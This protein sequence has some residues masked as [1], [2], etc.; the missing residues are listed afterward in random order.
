MGLTDNGRALFKSLLAEQRA[1]SVPYQ[2]VNEI[3]Y[4]KPID[5]VVSQFEDFLFY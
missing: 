4:N 5:K 2:L 3:G 1:N